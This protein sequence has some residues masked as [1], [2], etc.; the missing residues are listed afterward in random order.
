MMHSLRNFGIQTEAVIARMKELCR[1]LLV[2]F[3]LAAIGITFPVCGFVIVIGLM[4]QMTRRPAASRETHG[5]ARWASMCDLLYAGCLF[6]ASGVTAGRAFGSKPSRGLASVRP[7]LTYPLKQSAEAVVMATGTPADNTPLKLHIPDRFPHVAVF[8]SSGSGKSTCYAIPQL[9]DCSDNMI[10]LDAKGE[11][12]RIT[13]QHRAKAFLHQIVVIDP[14]DVATGC[15]FEKSRINPLDLFRQDPTRIV[16]EARRLASALVVTTGEEKDPFWPQAS[17]L[18]ITSVLAFLAAEAKPEDANLN[19]MRD[20]LTS[21]KMMD[22]MLAH[23]ENSSACGGL[24]RRL[25]GQCQQL[26]GQTKASVYSVANSH[27]DFLDSLPLAETLLE[28]TFDVRGL[29]EGRQTVYLCLPVDRISELPGLQRLLLTTF[30]NQV[31][32]AG[33]DP[34]RRVR[35]LLD[36]AATLGSMD[37]LY[38][39]VQ[40]GRSFGLRLMY[41]FQS[42]SQVERVFPESEKDSFFA[43]VATVHCGINDYASAKD[44]SE[45]IGQTTV[46]G[47]TD[48]T[49]S[50]WGQSSTTGAHDQSQGTNWGGSDSTSYAE[51]GR[52]LIQPEEILQLPKE[53]AIVLLPNVRPILAQKTPYFS[54]TKNKIGTRVARSLTSL[55]AVACTLALTGFLV[56]AMTAG[57]SHP[58]VLSFVRSFQQAP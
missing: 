52:A 18:L 20:L 19:T 45:W 31:F 48:Q 49:G 36:E 55:A 5:S 11:L 10:V 42:T 1:W 14:F 35:F 40:F 7:L 44:V 25:S 8:G 28:S 16:D 37:S 2:L 6:A 9:L 38:N 21:P 53:S 17:T 33:E 22:Q 26:S 3:M 56:W 43:T 58:L 46:V 24:L 32:A 27:I 23:M 4:W 29:I 12:A 15:G 41:L 47:R 54:R 30:I 50:N 57:R 39:A 34:N 13:A 51:V